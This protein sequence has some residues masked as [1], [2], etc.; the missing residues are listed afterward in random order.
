MMDP[1]LNANNFRNK[2]LREWKSQNKWSPRLVKH[3][4]WDST[5]WNRFVLNL[6]AFKKVSITTWWVLYCSQVK[7]EPK[8]GGKWQIAD[9]RASSR[10]RGEFSPFLATKVLSPYPPSCQYFN[11]NSLI[12]SSFMDLI[13]QKRTKS[14]SFLGFANNF[15]IYGKCKSLAY[16]QLWLVASHHHH[17]FPHHFFWDIPLSQIF[18][19]KVYLQLK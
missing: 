7:V 6:C 14:G 18:V 11:Q 8:E 16:S 4:F 17:V 9:R 3:F 13:C 2:V 5:L 19:S 1:L 10:S 12:F 15:C